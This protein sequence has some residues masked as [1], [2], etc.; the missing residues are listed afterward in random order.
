MTAASTWTATGALG[1]ANRMEL[2]FSGNVGTSTSRER[3]KA[4]MKANM[5][6]QTPWPCAVCGQPSTVGCCFIPDESEQLAYGAPSGTTRVLFYG[7]CDQCA[8]KAQALIPEI[9]Q[10]ALAECSGHTWN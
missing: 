4:T 8:A 7:L 2:H 5:K 1:A 3:I 10:P 9:E 6:N